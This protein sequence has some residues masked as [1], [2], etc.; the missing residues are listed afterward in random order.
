MGDGVAWLLTVSSGCVG[1]WLSEC[2]TMVVA[3]FERLAVE[4]DQLRGHAVS[5]GGG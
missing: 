1:G 3:A 5:C 4:T 2:V